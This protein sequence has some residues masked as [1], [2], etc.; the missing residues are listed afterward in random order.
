MDAI[1]GQKSAVE[2]KMRE[3]ALELSKSQELLSGER[4]DAASLRSTVSQLHD[5]LR[6]AQV[7]PGCPFSPPSALISCHFRSRATPAWICIS[8]INMCLAP[9]VAEEHPGIHP[10]GAAP[11]GGQL[12]DTVPIRRDQSCVAGFKGTVRVVRTGL[13]RSTID[14]LSARSPEMQ[15]DGTS[16]QGSSMSLATDPASI[17]RS[18][19]LLLRCSAAR[20]TWPPA[21]RYGA[22]T[23]V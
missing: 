4:R 2:A 9:G 3:T 7:T 20:C 18:R 15:A 8:R 12:V 17:S 21:A 13:G 16:R 19:V 14:A 5:V 22:G 6:Q 10:R 23:N 11:Q 1:Q